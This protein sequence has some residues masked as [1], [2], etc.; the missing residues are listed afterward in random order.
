M[1]AC[2]KRHYRA[3]LPRQTD[4]IADSLSLMAEAKSAE[5]ILLLV[6]DAVDAY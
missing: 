3:V 1:T 4:L 2:T 6:L 5:G